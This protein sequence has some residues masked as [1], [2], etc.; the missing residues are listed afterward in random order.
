MAMKWY[1]RSMLRS[2][3]PLLPFQPVLRKVKRT[4]MPFDRAGAGFVLEHGLAMLA[5]IR[6]SGFDFCGRTI[7]ELGTGWQPTIPIVL[8]FLRPKVVYLVDKHRLIDEITLR[9]TV[10]FLREHSTMIG[11]KLSLD[12][13]VVEDK[14]HN[15]EAFRFE[16]L[17]HYFNLKYRAPLDARCLDL[18]DASVDFIYSWMVLEHIPPVILS[19]I[20]KEFKRILSPNGLMVHTIDNSDHWAQKD[21]SISCVNFLRFEEWWWRIFNTN[22]LDYQNRLRVFDYEKLFING[23]FKCALT[24]SFVDERSLA[25]LQ[26]MRICSTYRDYDKKL[27]ATIGLRFKCWK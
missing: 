12:A 8:S 21:T 24:S 13:G 5:R 26:T 14:L 2:I 27:L 10:S 16:E 7:V 11:E 3:L 19:E 1:V 4:V 9:N 25:D 6:E 23:G 15:A 18:P 17:L 22:T 20:L